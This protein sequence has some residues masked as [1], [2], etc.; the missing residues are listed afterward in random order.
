MKK[1]LRV[2]K[3]LLCFIICVAVCITVPCVAA[4][5]GKS[6]SGSQSKSVL[7]IWQIDS[8][9]GGKGSRADFLQRIGN[10]FSEN[11]DCYVTVTSLSADAAR[12]NLSN[13]NVPDLISYGAGMYGIESFIDGWYGWCYGSYCLL[14]LDTNSDFSDVNASNTVINRGK[15]N[16]PSVAALFIGLEKADYEKPASAYVKLINGKYKY[17]LGTQR[18]VYR[19]KTRQVSFCVKAVTEYNDLYQNIS[20]TL[21]SENSAA[22]KRFIDYLLL[23]CGEVSALGL[24]SGAKTGYDDEMRNLEGQTYEYR[25]LSPV[26]KET[27]ERLK[28]LTAAGDINSLKNLLK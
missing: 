26:S 27:Y 15:D 12:I 25:V 4:S 18:D 21:Q 28:S 13:G 3:P 22:A 8:F 17:L 20:A 2:L 5:K 16:L 11:A 1:F 14:T 9:E 7:R 19:L 10:E 6:E 23:K 24:L